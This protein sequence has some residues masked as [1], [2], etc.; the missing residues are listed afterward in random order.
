M[1]RIQRHLIRELYDHTEQSYPYECCGLLVGTTDGQT[2]VAHAFRKCRNLNTERAHDRYEMDPKCLLDT[3]RE[4]AAGPWDPPPRTGLRIR[5]AP[6][7][8]PGLGLVSG[9][10]HGAVASCL[11]LLAGTFALASP[12]LF[13]GPALGAAIGTALGWWAP[14][15]GDR[16]T[17]T[18][19]DD[20]PELHL[21][22]LP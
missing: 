4:F 9:A 22:D 5:L 3:Q 10:V 1:I 12:W 14:G 13:T 8:R 19:G 7:G 15:R 6:A 18:A 11:V 17:T 21:I 20:G 16:P 2:R